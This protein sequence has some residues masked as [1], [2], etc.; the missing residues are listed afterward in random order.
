MTDFERHLAE[1]GFTPKQP[2]PP[3]KAET[4]RKP[5]NNEWYKQG[6]ECPF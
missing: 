5:T 4:V 2:A 3:E 6:K 1:L